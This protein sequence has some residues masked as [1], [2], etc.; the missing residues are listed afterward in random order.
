MTWNPNE[1][2][3]EDLVI[4]LTEKVGSVLLRL[5]VV[6]EKAVYTRK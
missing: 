2:S 5:C 3:I 6:A 4:L 1:C